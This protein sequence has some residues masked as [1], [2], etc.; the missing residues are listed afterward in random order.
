[1]CD[2]YDKSLQ[3]ILQQKS[4]HF[5]HTKG[6]IWWI[7]TSKSKRVSILCQRFLQEKHESPQKS[8]FYNKKLVNFLQE[9]AVWWFWWLLGHKCD[10]CSKVVILWNSTCLEQK[11]GNFT[12]K[13][14]NSTKMILQQNLIK[15]Y[16]I[17]ETQ[18]CT[19]KSFNET[20]KAFNFITKIWVSE[21]ELVS[22]F[23]RKKN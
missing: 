22:W 9:A 4:G 19:M 13:T 11:F 12:T 7:C 5:S 18:Y 10:C 23:Y 8:R 14:D 3:S 17:C 15:K 21:L 20:V 1:M 16:Q 6:A 2:F